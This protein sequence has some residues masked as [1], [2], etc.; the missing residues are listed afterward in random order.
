VVLDAFHEVRRVYPAARLILAPHEP[1]S[2]HLVGIRARATRLALPEPVLLDAA[3][4]ATPFVLVDR[5]GVLARLYGSGSLGF[6]GG[7][8][9]RAGIHSVIE[10]AGWGIPVSVGPRWQA[11]REAGLLASAG[12]ALILDQEQPARQL[13]EW[14]SRMLAEPEERESMGRRAAGVVEAGRGSSVRQAALVEGL[15]ANQRLRTA[16]PS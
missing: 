1:T 9:G 4:A 11:G 3:D 8:F 2:A 6:V 7:G 16:T 12:G 13:A 5:V 10:P 15:M 14:W